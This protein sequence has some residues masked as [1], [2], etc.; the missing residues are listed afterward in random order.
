LGTP[1]YPNFTDPAQATSLEIAEFDPT[2]G[3][4]LPFKVELNGEGRW[5][6]PS[7]YNYP[8]DAKDR[9]ART[10]GSL[11]DL[12][13]ETYRGD[14]PEDHRAMAVVDPMGARG[15]PE[16]MGKRVI[17]KDKTGQ[18]L[19]DLIIGKPVEGN[20]QQ[21]YV[22]IPGQNAVYGVDLRSADISAQFA[23]WIET[24]LLKLDAST[25]RQVIFPNLKF[26][27]VRGE[28]IK[29]APVTAIKRDPAKL[30]PGGAAWTL[31]STVPEG[32]E[33]NA[34]AL[35]T[36]GSTLAN[37]RI[38]GVRPKPP[39][40]SA[41]LR[42]GGSIKLDDRTM[43][44]LLRV[45]FAVYQDVLIS[46]EGTVYV[47]CDD[48]VVYNLHFGSI[49]FARGKA[50][51][52][53]SEG[54]KG[55]APA[56]DAAS[57]DSAQNL[58]ESRFLFVMAR[59]APE[60]VEKPRVPAPRELPDDVFARSK[61]DRAARD[62]QTRHALASAQEAYQKKL[63]AGEK[64]AQELNERFAAWYY[65]VPGDAFRKVVLEPA[66]LS[67]DKSAQPPM[68]APGAFPGGFPGDASGGLPFQL[69]G[70]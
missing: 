41:D 57:K 56:A 46:K 15:S 28:L 22:R 30:V 19:S 26:D 16:G 27:D 3:Q 8:A 6:I 2:T 42:T 49:I 70:R 24:N 7:H 47:V 50:L 37:L 65:L 36:L 66:A 40:L 35:D 21:R 31:D 29:G 53:G 18:V 54:E 25:I 38:V 68:G 5:V 17:L 9:L 10:A 13:R 44:A 11:L 52:A 48:G 45:G 14:R 20:A 4:P 1:L 58:V 32:K 39:G 64:R 43:D 61:A 69:P 63:E 51:S 62:E 34:S 12:Q 59:H 55:Q 33:V 60:Y 67:R 23:D